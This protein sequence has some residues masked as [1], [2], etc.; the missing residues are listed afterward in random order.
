[1]NI[2][3]EVLRRRYLEHQTQGNVCHEQAHLVEISWR[4]KSL[5]RQQKQFL[6]NYTG[7]AK[8]HHIFSNFLPQLETKHDFSDSSVCNKDLVE[9]YSGDGRC[10]GQLGCFHT[11]QI[12]GGSELALDQPKNSV[13]SITNLTDPA[14]G[15]VLCMSCWLGTHIW[16][17]SQRFV[18]QGCE[19]YKGI[20]VFQYY[21]C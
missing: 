1:M 15:L 16:W 13:M 20:V 14:K 19:V 12:V 2:Y 7:T 3:L 8:I 9:E 21:H 5:L 18:G 11:Y 6:I 17:S 10:L 4:L